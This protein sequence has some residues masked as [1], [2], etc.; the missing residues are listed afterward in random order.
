MI[1]AI[2]YVK[3]RSL[4]EALQIL[5]DPQAQAKI[6]A[7]GT[8]ILPGFHINSRRFREVKTLVDISGLDEL[9]GIRMADDGLHL[10]AAVT[11]TDVV[12]NDDIRQQ[13]P[14]LSQAAVQVGSVQIRNRATLTGNFVNNA[15]CADSVPPLLVYDAEIKIRSLKGER[16]LPLREFLIK[17]YRTQLQPD[18]MVTEIF[19]PPPPAGFEGA[20]YKLGRRRAVAI[21]RIT[22]ALLVK[23]N[24]GVI[25]D[26]RIASGAVTPIGARFPELEEKARGRQAEP[27]FLKDLSIAMGERILQITGL[28]WSSAY[29]LPVVQQV[30]YQLLSEVCDKERGER[31]KDQG[32]NK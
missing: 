26:I 17:P 10:G 32:N 2:D 21:S 18:E 8:D 3:P 12:K 25:E 20:F 19:L 4:S 15:P 5:S 30:F 9:R 29:K 13:Y 23:L 14:L 22:L 1:P 6:L 11:F 28:R 31:S 7:G 16:R 24:D 27:D